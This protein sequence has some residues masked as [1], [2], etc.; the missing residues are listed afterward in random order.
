[1]PLAVGQGGRRLHKVGQ[2][3]K[4]ASSQARGT[5]SLAHRLTVNALRPDGMAV[6]RLTREE[7]PLKEKAVPSTPGAPRTAPLALPLLPLAEWSAAVVPVASLK[8]QTPR[9]LCSGRKTKGPLPAEPSPARPQ[10][11][12]M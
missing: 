6:G 8:C 9:K 7:K 5:F 10:C 11:M 1:M 2:I 4:E 12:V 3:R